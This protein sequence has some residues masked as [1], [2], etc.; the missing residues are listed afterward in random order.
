ML[1][2]QCPV[3]LS[4]ISTN[5]PILTHIEAVALLY[6]REKQKFH[7][8]FKEIGDTQIPNFNGSTS[9][10]EI[11]ATNG[12]KSLWL[13]I[14]PYRVI[15]TQQ[16]EGQLNYRHFWEQGVYGIS[17]YW[18]HSYSEPENLNQNLR[19][20]NF[21]R[22]LTLKGKPLPRS[23]RIEYELWSDKLNLGHYILHL[24]VN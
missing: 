18:L 4:F 21:T 5:L 8:L 12:K 7:L 16:S 2:H 1:T 14:S 6:Q 9:Q 19:L 10:N 22:S 17:R 20:R 11:I 13:E 24:E 23:L 3:T 15:M